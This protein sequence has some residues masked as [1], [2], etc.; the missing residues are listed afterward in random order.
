MTLNRWRDPLPGTCSYAVPSQTR[1]SIRIFERNGG[2]SIVRSY[3]VGLRVFRAPC[4]IPG[5]SVRTGIVTRTVVP[6]VVDS[7]IISP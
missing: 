4:V 7:M 1:M 5:S 6:P 2:S 3:T